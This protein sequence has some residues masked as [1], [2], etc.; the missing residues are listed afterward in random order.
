MTSSRQRLSQ[1]RR[2]A[3]VVLELCIPLGMR[4][5]A[6]RWFPEHPPAAV[7]LLITQIHTS[8]FYLFG[9]YYHLSRRFAGVRLL[10]MSPQLTGGGGQ[11]RGAAAAS[12]PYVVVG[13]MLLVTQ[14]A[15][16]YKMVRG[17]SSAGTRSGAVVSSPTTPSRAPYD[18]EALTLN[19]GTSEREEADPSSASTGRCS[20]CLDDRQKPTA[21]SC[22]HVFCWDCVVDCCRAT[23]TCPLC[24]QSIA[25]ATLVRLSNF[26]RP[27]ARTS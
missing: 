14:L 24:R 27:P 12:N 1:L 2:I 4:E 7:A 26:S 17:G 13:L 8:I 18:R 15:A 22:G 25:A 21:T 3:V 16:L 10:A 9:A 23:G 19:E 20:L 5:A 11:P 6:L